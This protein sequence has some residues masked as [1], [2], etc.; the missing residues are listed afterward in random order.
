MKLGIRSF[1]EYGI[2]SDS[3][4]TFLEFWG[5][6]EFRED[7]LDKIRETLFYKPTNYYFE[8]NKNIDAVGVLWEGR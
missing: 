2:V 4:T 8:G 6:A 7:V 5:F 1:H 3:A